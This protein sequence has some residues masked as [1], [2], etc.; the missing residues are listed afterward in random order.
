MAMSSAHQNFISR[1]GQLA[2]LLL[3]QYGELAEQNVLWAGSP[4]YQTLITDE[5]IATVQSFAG[6]G[7][8]H[9]NMADAAYVM[10]QI[11]TLLTNGLPALTVLAN[12]P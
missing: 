12:L 2:K 6:A 3:D 9:Q 7:L 4:T 5:E 8:T 1:E 10:E 11:R